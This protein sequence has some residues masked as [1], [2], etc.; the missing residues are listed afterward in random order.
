MNKVAIVDG[1]GLLYHASKNTLEES[2]QSLNERIQNIFDK[3][4]ATHYVI[5]IS[6]TP[7]FRHKIDLEYKASR[8]K[9]KSNLKWLKTLKSYLVENWSAQSMN[10][11][12]ADD[13]C[14]Y[15]MNKEEWDVS[16]SPELWGM[17]DKVLC[18]PDKDLLQSIE[19]KHFNYSYKLEDKDN[20]ESVIKGWWV[21]TNKEEALLNFWYSMI[22]GDNT[23]NIKGIEGKGIKFAEKLFLNIDDAQS[24]INL[25]L[26]NY[27][28]KYGT[29]QG[30]FEFQ[31]N[32]RLLHLLENNKDFLREIGSIPKYPNI[33]EVP[34]KVIE[35]VI[36][37]NNTF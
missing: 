3:T 11:V 31:K 4:E 33:I 34:K 30:I 35:E 6:Y 16:T 13:L 26:E 7:Y 8:T 20:P 14:S 5:F 2:I 36:E 17:F 32:Y 1:D 21:E 23:D 10:N 19:G 18:S 37:E 22:C 9:Q 29:S 24:L 27:I 25:T 12:E 28:D 15:W